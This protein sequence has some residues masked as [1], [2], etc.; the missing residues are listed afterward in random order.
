MQSTSAEQSVSLRQYCNAT[1]TA[2]IVAKPLQNQFR[3]I[4]RHYLL[5]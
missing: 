5:Q 4:F 1:E 3:S 2:G